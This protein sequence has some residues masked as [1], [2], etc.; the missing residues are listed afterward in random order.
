LGIQGGVLTAQADSGFN[1]VTVDH[2]LMAGKGFADIN[3]HFFSDASY[4][5]IR[6]NGGAGGTVTNIHSTVKPL[7][8]FGDSAKD[9][10][11]LGDTSNKL[12]GILGT[13]LLED[14]KG[15][16]ATVNINDQGDTTNLAATLS[17]VPRAGDSSLGQLTGLG[18]TIQWDYADISV[19]NLNLSPK[20]GTADVEGIGTTT[21]ILITAPK[22]F[23]PVG[24]GNV[25]ANIQG[26]LNLETQASGATVNILDKND[27]QGHTATL[28]TVSRLNQS[29][30]GQ[31]S[32]LGSAVITWDSL[33]TSQVVVVGGS[34]TN[35]FNIQ[36]TVVPI[37]IHANGP[38]TMNVGSSGSIAGIQSPLVL[39]ND[40]GPT[41][42]VNINAQN[43]TKPAL[44]FTQGG[45]DSSSGVGFLEVSG[46][47]FIQWDNADTAALN[48]N[49][50][51]SSVDVE[52][53]VV[54]TNIFSSGN[55]TINVGSG[56]LAGIKGALNLE[57]DAPGGGSLNV[58]INGQNDAAPQ[59][60]TLS[61]ITRP[62]DLSLFGAVNGLLGGAPITWDYADTSGVSLHLGSGAGHVKVLGT[63]TSTYIFSSGTATIDVGSGSLAGIKGTLILQNAV[64]AADTVNING[65]NDAAFQ[66]VSLS[67]IPGPGASLLGA[68]N[69]L[70][71][72][73]QITYDYASTSAVSL[74]LG[75]GAIEVNVN[76]TGT[77]I[78][79]IANSADATI[80]VGNGSLA[81]IH[82]LLHLLNASSGVDN[83][84]LDDSTD[85]TVG[86]TYNLSSSPFNQLTSSAMSG[87]I[88]WDSAGTNSVTLFGGSGGNTFNIF[89]TN[90]ATEIFGGL[91][92]NT[93]NV[94][95]GHLAAD[96]VGTLTLHG[97]D[98]VTG[99]PNT[100]LNL[101]DQSDPNSETFHFDIRPVGLSHLTLGTTPTFNLFFDNMSFVDLVTTRLSTVNDPSGTVQVFF[102]PT[103]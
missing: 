63:G 82:G 41:N 9:V 10:V 11:N 28:A 16:K 6:I 67:S 102:P 4:K 30:L 61:T 85:F 37:A 47:G 79:T 92:P 87:T 96:I 91:G 74:N 40:S 65:Q 56:S 44:L 58:G 52:A 48:L 86:Q 36:G 69:G 32:G 64:P 27:T 12:Q 89:G 84:I 26:S 14:E 71:G 19:V 77:G 38:A 78:T 23:V 46:P 42:T 3:G 73:A 95:N 94:G 80:N 100:G 39:E 34:G 43:D 18:A 88:R 72:G 54:P 68:V 66:A 75:P 8:V 81:E 103:G 50:G 60:V 29:S 57:N 97:G 93:F 55:A 59:T 1:T 7:T 22:A 98:G 101:F 76:G 25:A 99:D 21:N 70:L 24:N 33:G 53:T 2:V 35:T 17:T 83:I 62:G 13:V 15:F 5:S 90:V 49:L 20:T 45:G 51:S 31:L